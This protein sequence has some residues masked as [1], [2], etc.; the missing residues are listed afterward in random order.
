MK[1]PRR[2]PEEP[3]W[4]R[5]ER[6]T[7]LFARIIYDKC[8]FAA[9]LGPNCGLHGS[10][11]PS[12]AIKA[13]QSARSSPSI[14]AGSETVRPTPS[15]KR[16]MNRFRNRRSV[17]ELVS[18]SGCRV[19]RSFAPTPH[20]SREASPD[21]QDSR[22]GWRS[23]SLSDPRG[24]E[25]GWRGPHRLATPPRSPKAFVD[26]ADARGMG[27]DNGS[28][29]YRR[30]SGDSLPMAFARPRSRVHSGAPTVRG[31]IEPLSHV[32][33]SGVSETGR[34]IGNCKSASLWN[35]IVIIGVFA[36]SWAGSVIIYR[37]KGF[38]QF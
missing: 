27:R 20:G 36:L 23:R 14:S 6:R 29:P 12:D 15:R 33:F 1:Y 2:L 31:T 32:L 26:R 38:D 19:D 16:V 13:A 37:A 4:Q 35:G 11:R 24:C 8:G 21:A 7:V 25:P 10:N 30:F 17:A 9:E 22:Y 28:C 3:L 5:L 34:R 18:A